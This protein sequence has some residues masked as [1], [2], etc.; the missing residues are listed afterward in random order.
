MLRVT[1]VWVLASAILFLAARSAEGSGGQLFCFPQV[2]SYC[3]P[4]TV[5]CLPAGSTLPVYG[6]PGAAGPKKLYAIP[7]P[8]PASQ[9]SEPPGN[10]SPKPII[11][12]A[13]STGGNYSGDKTCKVGFWNLSGRDMAIRV[14]GTSRSVPRDRA[15]ILDLSREFVWRIEGREPERVVV[16]EGK[17]AHEV[18]LR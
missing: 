18:V 15:V 13:Q 2:A 10:P 3:P 12:E 6:P 14:N 9:T 4:V 16:P 8:A 7:K 17:S 5:I 1:G 11:R